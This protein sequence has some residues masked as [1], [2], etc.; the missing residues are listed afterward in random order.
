MKILIVSSLPFSYS[1]GVNTHLQ[2]LLQALSASGID[3]QMI[4]TNESKT[5]GKLRSVRSLSNF[6]AVGLFN[7][8]AQSQKVRYMR[9]SIRERI[10]GQDMDIIHAHDVYA[11]YAAWL[12]V[13]NRIPMLFTMHGPMSYEMLAV[14]EKKSSLRIRRLRSYERTVY[15]NAAACIAV[16]SGQKRILVE[17][18]HV[19]EESVHT[20]YNAV[21]VDAV[22]SLAETRMTFPLSGHFFLVPR[23]L[24]PKNGV[25]F[26]IRALKLCRK[27]HNLVIAG[28]GPQLGYLTKL[29]VQ[30]GVAD[31]V[32]FLGDLVPQQLM[33]LMKNATGVMVPSVPVAGVVEAT[34]LA[35][36]EA[37][38]LQ[39]PVIA[40]KIGGIWEILRS[41]ENAFLTAP[42][43]VEALA[44][45]MDAMLTLDKG[46]LEKRA[47]RNFEI[48]Q[49]Y[50]SLPVWRQT[51]L[52]I[53][54]S[55]LES[56][57]PGTS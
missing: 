40:S 27:K 11:A 17:D 18:Y 23:R 21:D 47:Q 37:M 32:H 48:V 12:E 53:Y 19:A 15:G 29:A 33:P 44:S 35:V 14:G 10:T 5:L 1:G 38:A 3:H 20:V 8:W 6:N 2:H 4:N 13:Q 45:A 42:G 30:C 39:R 52:D 57:R 9:R 34:S 56:K 51:M 7:V 16:D 46:E 22:Q 54:S 26:A 50:H 43:D 41:E 24:V 25:E 55:L 28:S 36:L 49:K 31:Q